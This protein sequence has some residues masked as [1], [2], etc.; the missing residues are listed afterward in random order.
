MLGNIF[1]TTNWIQKNINPSVLASVPCTD[2]SSF[3]WCWAWCPVQ[4]SHSS[5]PAGQGALYSCECI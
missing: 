2:L 4:I 1:I 3:I 5:Y